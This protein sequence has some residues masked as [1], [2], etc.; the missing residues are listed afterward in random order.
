MRDSLGMRD[1]SPE[2]GGAGSDLDD[3]GP[4]Q[5]QRRVRGHRVALDLVPVEPQHLEPGV[6]HDIHHGAEAADGEL[7]E[8]EEMELNSLQPSP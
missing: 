6:V 8:G 1:T 5:A 7:W 4:A 3:G 2:G